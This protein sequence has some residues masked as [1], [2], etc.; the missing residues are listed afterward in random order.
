MD[1]LSCLVN[2]T[3]SMEELS[4]KCVVALHVITT[5]TYKSHNRL[6]SNHSVVIS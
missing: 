3:S 2:V 1:E 4:H 5:T 6:G